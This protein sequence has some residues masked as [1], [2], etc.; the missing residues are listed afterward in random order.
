MMNGQYLMLIIVRFLGAAFSFAATLLIARLAGSVVSGGYALAVQTVQVGAVV[1]LF[2]ND[3]LLVRRM[4]GDLAEDRKDL[5][6]AALA[7]AVRWVG[8]AAAVVAG[9][10]LALSLV[11]PDFGAS[12]GIVALSS[13]GIVSYAMLGLIVGAMRAMGRA[14][15]SQL[16][17]GVIHAFLVV[18]AVGA[19]VLSGITVTVPALVTSLMLSLL[20]TAMIG[21]LIVH[22]T[23]RDW[24]RLAGAG[25]TYGI[26]GSGF[27]G[28]TQLVN[29]FN[30]WLMM[31]LIA[32]I[33]SVGDL[34]A[35]RVCVQLITVISMIVVTLG[36]VIGP[37]FAAD[38]RLGDMDR[39][40]RRYLR[41]IA[42]FAL[43]AGPPIVVML[44]LPTPILSM[45]GPDFVGASGALQVLAIGQLIGLLTGPVGWVL[46]MGGYER[47]N[48]NLAIGSFAIT[49]GLLT[50]AAP[51]YGLTGAAWA[52]VA[53][54]VLKNIGCLVMMI[55]LLRRRRDDL[56]AS[57]R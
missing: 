22:R 28:A 19:M 46:I 38:F 52:M 13:I 7:H 39:V 23:M 10:V 30:G 21:G 34:G 11:I 4:V 33:I 26:G 44:A 12:P 49:L 36:S 27:I 5:A 51:L 15:M 8:T 17:F 2:G 41:S 57:D 3:Y 16:F 20:A 9:A 29:T 14:V 32:H 47:V 35:F 40:R 50:I 48:F 25:P 54:D 42:V 1:S 55:R 43:F 37:Q 31:V 53:G 18:L 24:P 45:F 6:R 56:S